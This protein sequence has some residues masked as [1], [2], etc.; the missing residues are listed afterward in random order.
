MIA[1][2][3]REELRRNYDAFLQAL[4]DLLPDHE[5]KYALMR[6]R[7]VVAYFDSPRE[8]LLSGRARYEDDLFSVQEVTNKTADFGWYSRAPSNL[9][10]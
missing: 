5:G 10:V 4:P 6:H 7:S 3:K 2:Q 8:A 9:P 1:S